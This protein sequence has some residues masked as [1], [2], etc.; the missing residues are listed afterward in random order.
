MNHE[1]TKW[2]VVYYTNTE[3]YSE[4]LE[5]INDRKDRDKAK[6]LAL[7]TVLEEQGPHPGLM[8]TF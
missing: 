5:F 4:V 1:R 3:E 8:Q 2:H 7:L 6:I